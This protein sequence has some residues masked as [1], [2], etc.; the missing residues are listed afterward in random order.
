MKKCDRIVI[1]LLSLFVFTACESTE[2]ISAN[3]TSGNAASCNV[4]ST[5]EVSANIVSAN[6]TCENYV[7]GN[8]AVLERCSNY[9][10]LVDQRYET[11]AAMGDGEGRTEFSEDDCQRT[12]L[13][14][15]D[16]DSDLDT[17]NLVSAYD[18]RL[19]EYVYGQWRFVERIETR[20]TDV[21]P[22]ET[23]E[24]YSIR[25]FSEQAADEIKKNCVL[26]IGPD[27]AYMMGNVPFTDI[28]EEFRR[29]V[30]RMYY[31]GG[32]LGVHWLPQY[33]IAPMEQNLVLDYK[34]TSFSDLRESDCLAEIENL[35]RVN[36]V[37]SDFSLL[38]RYEAN[39]AV[40][41]APH[42]SAEKFYY[43]P[44]EP[45]VFY[46]EFCGIWKLERDYT[47]YMILVILNGIGSITRDYL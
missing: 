4:V 43:S 32:A 25:D 31:G 37:T 21:I 41:D 1:S 46:M 28:E 19:Q 12:N 3:G 5:N 44:S 17:A 23:P 42:W 30:V 8:A 14:Y 26:Y 38:D 18:E 16:N 24:D 27:M 36:I 2:N 6:L 15:F 47:D 34:E 22:E 13:D 9:Y 10:A 29:Q 45:D 35:Q 40:F 33:Y 7:S 11:I 20:T 39:Y